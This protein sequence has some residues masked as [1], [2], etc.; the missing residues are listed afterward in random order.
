MN[1]TK[2]VL[3]SILAVVILS[4][5]LFTCGVIGRGANQ[6]V[7][8]THV[9]DATIVYEEFQNV[10]NTC[11]KINADLGVLKEADAKDPMFDQ[12]SKSQQIYT[13]KTQ[14]NRW[15]EEYNAKSKMWGRSLWKS[16]TLPYQ[17]TAN[18]FSN[19]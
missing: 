4:V 3:L 7:V 5:T 11:K 2:A 1:T 10:F 15:M 17:L 9:D 16:Q 13:K 18:D 8:A 6:A 12:F 19:Y 14:L